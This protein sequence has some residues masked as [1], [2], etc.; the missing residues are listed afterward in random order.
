MNHE[1][2]RSAPRRGPRTRAALAVAGL[3]ALLAGC[4]LMPGGGSVVGGSAAPADPA[5]AATPTAGRSS[6]PSR[7]PTPNSNPT[8]ARTTTHATGSGR[9]SSPGACPAGGPA[10][11]AGADPV[12][13]ADL[14]GDGRAD[15][16][17]LA[18]RGGKRIL[19]VRTASGARFS[20]TFSSAAPQAASA[21]AGRLADGSAVVLLDTG[22][23]AGLYLVIDCHLATALNAQGEPYVFDKGFTGFGTGAG[24]PTVGS[25]RVLAGYLATSDGGGDFRV[26]RTVIDLTPGTRRAVNGAT[27]TLGTGLSADSPVVRTATTV[28]C[29]GDAAHEPQ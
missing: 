11:P 19:G 26:T 13:T 1:P 28:A 10:L 22:R 21:T 12:R 9:P 4:S 5:I 3:T 25:K 6:S 20:T 29:T 7:T 14:D 2:T 24:C 18:D 27:T 17:W 16:I 15:S 8:P 23:S